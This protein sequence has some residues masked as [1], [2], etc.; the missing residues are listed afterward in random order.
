MAT[1]EISVNGKVLSGTIKGYRENGDGDNGGIRVK[2]SWA[3]VNRGM[4]SMGGCAWRWKVPG[5]HH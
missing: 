3:R 1:V 2:E 4:G 5:G